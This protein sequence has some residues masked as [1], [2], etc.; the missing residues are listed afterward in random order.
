M[1]ICS[2]RLP[3]LMIFGTFGIF[4]IVRAGMLRL[5]NTNVAVFGSSKSRTSLCSV[6]RC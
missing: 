1:I 3:D 5:A 4:C 6:W 2:L